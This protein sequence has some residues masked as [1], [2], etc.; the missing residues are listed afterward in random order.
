MPEWGMR[1]HG[2]AAHLKVGAAP[3][4]LGDWRQLPEDAVQSAPLTF[5]RPGPRRASPG[6]DR[7][8]S[9]LSESPR[10]SAGRLQPARA[11]LLV[12]VVDGHGQDGGNGSPRG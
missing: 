7:A 6:R 8:F 5:E 1:A 10:R 12:Q 4:L 2:G 11:S 9:D 3:H